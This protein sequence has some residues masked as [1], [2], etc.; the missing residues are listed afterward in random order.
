MTSLHPL[1]SHLQMTSTTQTTTTTNSTNTSAAILNGTPSL[2]MVTGPTS[3]STILLSANSSFSNLSPIIQRKNDHPNVHSSY[4][5]SSTGGNPINI[6]TNSNITNNRAIDFDTTSIASISESSHWS[7]GGVDDLDNVALVNGSDTNAMQNKDWSTYLR[8]S[9]NAYN[10]SEDD[11]EEDDD[12][13][14]DNDGNDSRTSNSNRED[15]DLIHNN[16][17][18]D[19]NGHQNSNYMKNKVNNSSI[20]QTKHIVTNEDDEEDDTSLKDD[21]TISAAH[22]PTFVNKKNSTSKTKAH[23]QQSK[24]SK[25]HSLK[26]G[27]NFKSNK[28]PN[29]NKQI[30]KKSVE[31]DHE[32]NTDNDEVDDSYDVCD[33]TNGADEQLTSKRNGKHKSSSNTNGHHRPQQESD[34]VNSSVKYDE[35]EKNL[36]QDN[37][38]ED[39]YLNEEEDEEN[40]DGDGQDDESNNPNEEEED[41]DEE[42]DDDDEED[43]DEDDDDDDDLDNDNIWTIKPKLLKYYEKQF[44]TMQPNLNGYITGA[45]ARPFFERSKLPVDEL[46]KIWE[47]SDVTKDGALS[48][49]EFCT[50]MH[51]VVLR[52]R[53]FDLPDQLPSKLQPYAPLIDFNSETNLLDLNNKVKTINNTK[54]EQEIENQTVSTP[55][56]ST[57]ATGPKPVMFGVKPQVQM[58]TQLIHHP[59]P[60]R[61]NANQVYQQ[62]VGENRHSRSSSPSVMQQHTPI[63]TSA[64]TYAHQMAINQQLATPNINSIQVTTPATITA[65]TPKLHQ[66]PQVP[67]RIIS[68]PTTSNSNQLIDGTSTTISAGILPPP[69]PPL[70]HSHLHHYQNQQQHTNRVH[71]VN[72]TPQMSSHLQHH[73]VQQSHAQSYAQYQQTPSITVTN[74]HRVAPLPP[75][76]PPPST[77][78]QAAHN[79][80]AHPTSYVQSTNAQSGQIQQQSQHQITQQTLYQQQQQSN[81]YEENPVVTLEKLVEQMSNM[82]FERLKIVNDFKQ[83]LNTQQAS[84]TNS[85]EIEKLK[86]CVRTQTEQNH[87]LKRMFN[88]LEK[89]LRSLTENRIELEIKLDYL[90]TAAL[91]NSSSTSSTT[92]AQQQQVTPK[93]PP[94]IQMQNTNNMKSSHTLINSTP[95]T[96]T[97]SALTTLSSSVGS[98]IDMTPQTV[99]SKIHANQ[100]TLRSTSTT[101]PATTIK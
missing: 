40:E 20:K 99:Q 12:D 27:E 91:T 93:P 47:L 36:E 7:G 64:A 65:A 87:V 33:S 53:N 31:M 78:Q 41:E 4:N 10:S 51:L 55:V 92:Q 3:S 76:P 25:K 97:S 28:Q 75:L 22:Q 21:R 77:M 19:L 62:S 44:K 73:Q 15:S 71:L 26:S 89:E 81:S 38:N 46:S 49:S 85:N 17:Y 61:Y 79:Q 60:L 90:N 9:K 16:L 69:P 101:T 48:F 13:G 54:N 34:E 98:N 100:T 82:N 86:Q 29:A 84:I 42:E 59:V 63:N 56:D 96:T 68:P 52:V 32:D 11:D 70:S 95:T 45:V 72:S 18:K 83:T 74:S 43:D 57:N 24:Q 35:N 66:P 14:D 5:R 88:E 8:M 37:G 6:S 80:T 94:T 58:D 1:Q 2:S 50:A 67:P 39:D 23:I 30:K